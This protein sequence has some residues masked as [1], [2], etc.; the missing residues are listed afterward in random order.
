MPFLRFLINQYG[1][2]MPIFA[3]MELKSSKYWV[4]LAIPAILAIIIAFS[5]TK[6]HWIEIYYSN[7]L[8]PIISRFLRFIF[9]IF[10]FS[11]GDILYLLAIIFFIRKSIKFFISLKKSE[12]R[13]T[14]LGKALF[15]SLRLI[16]WIYCFFNILWGLNYSR[17]GVKS[18]FDLQLQPITP[19]DLVVLTKILRDSVNANIAP[20]TDPFY[21]NGDISDI[22]NDAYKSYEALERKYP[23]I[24][25]KTQSLKKSLFRKFGNYMGYQGYYNPFTGESQVNTNIPSFMIPF[26]ACHEIAHQA[27]FASESEAN[28]VGFIAA[29]HAE[30]KFVR[31]SAFL[32]MYLYASGQLISVDTATAKSIALELHPLAKNDIHKY[33]NFLKDHSSIIQDGTNI[34]YDFYL[35]QNDQKNGIRSYGE[36]TGWLVAY[37]KKEENKK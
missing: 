26:V 21:E 4:S 33:I 31:Y 23:F 2:F 35:K 9:G 25:I 11:I 27:G 22:E 17:Q 36:V 28:F 6:P 13:K 10:P 3:E 37:F 7:G 20:A 19:K 29:T 12:S 18:A 14:I 16:L 32:E 34:F 30:K 15:K 1:I 24:S 8:Y 5:S